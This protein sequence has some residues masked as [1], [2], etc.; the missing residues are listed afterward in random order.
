MCVLPLWLGQQGQRISSSEI[1]EQTFGDMWW[2]EKGQCRSRAEPCVT[3]RTL[4]AWPWLEDMTMLLIFLSLPLFLSFFLLVSF[5]SRLCLKFVWLPEMNS[6][7]FQR[8]LSFRIRAHTKRKTCQSPA[9]VCTVLSRHRLSIPWTT[10]RVN[11]KWYQWATFGAMVPPPGRSGN[12][13]LCY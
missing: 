2:V 11:G 8:S 9:H 7:C 1:M 13:S 10:V 5:I 12:R 4:T 6:E 3:R